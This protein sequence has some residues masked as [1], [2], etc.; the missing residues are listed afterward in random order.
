MEQRHFPL[1]QAEDPIDSRVLNNLRELA[2]ESPGFLNELI[3]IFLVD[4]AGYLDQI[5]SAISSRDRVALLR[6]AHLL[7]GSCGNVGASELVVYAN[8][9]EEAVALDQW[10]V[11]DGTMP[12]LRES[13]E[14]VRSYLHGQLDP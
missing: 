3:G 13:F 5:Q 8:E 14:R 10:A 4:A 9:L 12:G 1:D 7:K 11:L 6:M 2:R